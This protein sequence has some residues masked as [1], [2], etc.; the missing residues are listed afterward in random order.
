MR[1]VFKRLISQRSFIFIAVAAG[2]Q[3]FGNYGVGNW[4]PPF[5]QRSHGIDIQTAGIIL[6][7]LAAFGGGVG[8]FMGGYLTDRLRNR[9]I[10]WYLWLPACAALFALLPTIYIIYGNNTNVVIGML[11]LTYFSTALYLGPSI[12]TT[13]SLV[14]AKMRAFAS[15]ILFFILN[16]ADDKC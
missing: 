1:D 4:L 12:A 7:L 14:P 13:H 2:F 11:F 3:A 9:N 16:S 5:L 15:G 8:T 6:G 10:R